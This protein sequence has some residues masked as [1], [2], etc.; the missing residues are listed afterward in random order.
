MHVYV[1]LSLWTT[2]VLWDKR[3]TFQRVLITNSLEEST[4]V[5]VVWSS[6]TQTAQKVKCRSIGFL[7][8]SADKDGPPPFD[9]ECPDGWLQHLRDFS[10][11]KNRTSSITDAGAE[12][13]NISPDSSALF[14]IAIAMVNMVES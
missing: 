4:L 12:T 3:T 9:P 2:V 14:L 10:R 13:R 6:T 5:V 1:G 7:V 11:I 8:M